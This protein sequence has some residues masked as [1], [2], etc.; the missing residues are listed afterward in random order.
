MTEQVVSLKSWQCPINIISHV[1]TAYDYSGLFGVLWVHMAWWKHCV[2]NYFFSCWI[3]CQRKLFS[4]I[5]V[6]APVYL[7]TREGELTNLC[8][9]TTFLFMLLERGHPTNACMEKCSLKRCSLLKIKFINYF[10]MKKWPRRQSAR[11]F[12][13]VIT[14]PSVSLAI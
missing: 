7:H 3:S 14:R 6:W 13:S 4:F 12:W 2:S 9:L 8:N 11:I 1:H 10:F 5:W